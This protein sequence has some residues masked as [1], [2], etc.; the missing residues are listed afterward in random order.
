MLLGCLKKSIADCR[1]VVGLIE[2]YKPCLN[3]VPSSYNAISRFGK[4]RKEIEE[5]VSESQDSAH[6]ESCRTFVWKPHKADQA[7]EHID[8]SSKDLDKKISKERAAAFWSSIGPQNIYDEHPFHGLIN[9]ARTYGHHIGEIYVSIR[10]SA[11]DSH[12]ARS[13][14]NVM[15]RIG[16]S[17]GKEGKFQ[18]FAF[19]ADAIDQT[20]VTFA[21]KELANVL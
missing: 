12:E 15:E 19:V 6:Q 18:H 8:I 17:E 11:A 2:Q 1:R 14:E 13:E 5:L 20:E 16:K 10:P 21:A 4:L 7:S 3:A 9:T